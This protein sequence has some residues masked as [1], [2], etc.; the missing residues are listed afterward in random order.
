MD[1]ED[2]P[3]VGPCSPSPGYPAALWGQRQAEAETPWVGLGEALGEVHQ[4][5]QRAVGALRGRTP[6]LG[7]SHQETRDLP[8]AVKRV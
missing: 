1:T 7:S 2:G 8:E 5:Q 3:L 4:G 6:V